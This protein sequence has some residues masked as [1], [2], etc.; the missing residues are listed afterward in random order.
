MA[1]LPEYSSSS[2]IFPGHDP[3]Q[4]C[5]TLDDA[6]LDLLMKMCQVCSAHLR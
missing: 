3:H 2:P 6:G 4:I 5:P 1:D